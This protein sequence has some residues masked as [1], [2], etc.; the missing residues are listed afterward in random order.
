MTNFKKDEVVEYTGPETPTLLKGDCCI[1]NQNYNGIGTVNCNC[2]GNQENIPP[3]Y[4]KRGC[5]D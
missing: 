3:K 4:L 2:G 5:D 1:V